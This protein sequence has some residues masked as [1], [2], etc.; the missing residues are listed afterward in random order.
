MP[1]KARALRRTFV[2]LTALSG[3]YASHTI[4]LEGERYACGCRYCPIV[5]DI[6]VMCDLADADCDITVGT[7]PCHLPIHATIRPCTVFEGD[8]DAICPDACP[9]FTPW[10]TTFED[11]T[12]ATYAA[13]GWC[14]TG[15]VPPRTFFYPEIPADAV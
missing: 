13:S 6:E 11:V 2:T 10:G 3:C 5:S 15:D 14:S 1:S 4:P 7:G 8:P 12:P 9:A